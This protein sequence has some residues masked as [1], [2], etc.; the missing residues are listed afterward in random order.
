MEEVWK[1]VHEP[2]YCEL[3]E[4]S[5][6]GNV[7]SRTGKILNQHMKCGYKAVYFE[8]TKLK[9]KKTPYVHKLVGNAFIEKPNSNGKKLIVNH[10]D[11]NKLNNVVDNLE[12]TTYKGNNE[13]AIKNG[14]RKNYKLPILQI[15]DSGNIIKEYSSIIE[16]SRELNIS[17]NKISLVCKGKR[18]KTG[19][20]KWRYKNQLPSDDVNLLDSHKIRKMVDYPK[21]YIT[22][23]GKIFSTSAKR[24]LKIKTDSSGYKMIDIYKGGIQRSIL[25]HREVANLFIENTDPENKTYVNHINKVKDDNRVENLEWVTPS[26]NMFHAYKN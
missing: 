13:H 6:L 10:K 12:W 2:N 21:Y 22:R 18:N 16:A 8:N 26:E 19:G 5:N 11:G 20:F 15:D 23:D 25:M 17:D 14:L 24:F 9:T 4:V 1:K 3:Y 7:K